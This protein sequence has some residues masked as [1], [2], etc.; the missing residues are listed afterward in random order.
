VIIDDKPHFL[1]VEDLLEISTFNTK[2]L[3]GLELE[4]RKNELL[5]KLH[6]ASLEKIFIEERIYRD[7]E[8]C[9]TWEAVL[10][11][12]E[13]GLRKYVRTPNEKE[14]TDDDRLL[15]LRD[16]TEEDL[17]RLTEIKIKRISK[18]NSFKA[19]EQIAKLKEELQEV[20]HHLANLTDFTIAYF[21]Q[22]LAKHGKGKE[23]RTKI[24]T[25]DTIQVTEVV[26]NNA[27]L[28]VNK[29]EGF[30]GTGIKKGRI[31]M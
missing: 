2:N 30:I 29:K 18:F 16:I 21:E 6:F 9:E 8:E 22:L 10:E 19:D 24:T 17:I 27:K 25:F 12:V 4:I 14:Q 20:E 11:A 13:A 31:C 15:L 7:I 28:Y 1:A 3:L 26:A 5:E 23:R